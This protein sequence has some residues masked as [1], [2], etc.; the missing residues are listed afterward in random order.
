MNPMYKILVLIN[1][2]TLISSIEEIMTDPGNPDCR[3]V[4]PYKVIGNLDEFKLE[5]WIP[6]TE[7]EE[8]LIHSTNILTIVDPTDKILES[9]IE[10][11]K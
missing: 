5:K 3:I 7:Q 10:V 6:F 2:I 4:N 1:G 11:T 8:L 9:Y